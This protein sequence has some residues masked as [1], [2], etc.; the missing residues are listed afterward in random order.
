MQCENL[1]F[2][3]SPTSLKHCAGLRAGAGSLSY[4]IHVDCCGLSTIVVKYVIR[5][6]HYHGEDYCF[7]QY[8]YYFFLCKRSL[9]DKHD[10]YTGMDP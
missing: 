8:Y 2:H 5:L 10:T 4:I 1:D 7:C 9:S 3:H 6:H